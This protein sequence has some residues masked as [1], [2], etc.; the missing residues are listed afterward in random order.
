MQTIQEETF[1]T[2]EFS[3]IIDS[4]KSINLQLQTI[5]SS[6]NQLSQIPINLQSPKK[7]KIKTT[8]NKIPDLNLPPSLSSYPPNVQYAA[9]QSHYSYYTRNTSINL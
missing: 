8:R 6:K 2:N 3:N 5:T 9:L 4:F 1:S 7:I